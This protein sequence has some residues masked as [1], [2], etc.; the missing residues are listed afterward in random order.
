MS[1][2]FKPAL[3]RGDNPGTLEILTLKVMVGATHRRD[4]K[5]HH[6]DD[7]SLLRNCISFAGTIAKSS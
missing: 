2:P 5:R 1:V 4:S 6:R 3:G 7:A